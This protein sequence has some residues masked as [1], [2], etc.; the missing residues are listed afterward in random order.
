MKHKHIIKSLPLLASVLG[1]KYGVQVR[2]G[3]D[4]AFTNGNVIQLPSLPLD[5]D[6]TLLGLIRGMIDHESAHI[7]DTDFRALKAA[8]LT[9]LEK[10]IWNTIEDWRAENALAA[11]Y[12][13]CRENFQWLIKH[14]FLPKTAKGKASQQ[15][16]DPAT[17]ILDW[18]LITVRSWDV[19]EL[20]PERDMLRATAEIYFPGLTHELEP[21]LRQVPTR[22]M[23]TQDG[24]VIARE[25]TS[26]ISK[27]AHFLQQ[28]QNRQTGQQR[29]ST[30]AANSVSAEQNSGV[31]PAEALQSLQNILSAGEG[32]LPADIGE[33]LRQALTGACQEQGQRLWVA[34]PTS[35]QTNPLPPGDLDA[36]RQATTALRTKLQALMQ[37]TR[38]VRNHSGYAG[39]LNTRKLHTLA[40][41]NAK[42]FLRKGEHIGV[43]TAVHILLDASGSMSGAAMTL[44]SQ[45]CFAVAS[46]LHGIK[47]I[48]IGV[49]AFPGER[50]QGQAATGTPLLRFFGTTR[51]CIRTSAWPEPAAHPWTP[52]S[53]GSSSRSIPCPSRARSSCSSQTENRITKI[54][55][56]QPSKPRRVFLLKCTALALR[57][58]PSQGFCRQ[59]TAGSSTASTNWLW[60]CSACC[61]TRCCPAKE[62]AMPEIA[63]IFLHWSESACIN[64]AFGVEPLRGSGD[65]N[66][67]VNPEHFSTLC[68]FASRSITR[69]YEKNMID[70]HYVNGSVIHNYRL[71]LTRE[72]FLIVQRHL[73]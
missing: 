1:R 68:C 67:F 43:N 22:C 20:V 16:T 8:N 63:G 59:A 69:G 27:Y 48:S 37:S 35:R 2:I 73:F 50:I 45:A 70:I 14:L 52:P 19:P 25:I 29:N 3:G 57:P 41:G 4:K 17:G 26:I 21:T 60:P 36:S 33:Q 62:G 7:R 13:G 5:C 23:S 38:S 42:L 65:I 12:P 58:H 18:L 53:G 44:A 39:R 6:D 11:I 34:T 28:Q 47:G 30:S 32:A 54:W 46:A 56:W 15:K 55:P 31:D 64:A 40:S 72:R 49:T 24:I 71:D 61:R 51:N 10:H 9:P 66:R